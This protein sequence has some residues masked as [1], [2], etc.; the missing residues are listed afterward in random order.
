MPTHHPITRQH[1]HHSWLS[2][3][4]LLCASLACGA[5]QV[6]VHDP[7]MTREGDTWYLFSTGPGITIYSSKD[8]VNWRYSDRA[9]GTEPTWAKRVSPSFDGHLWAPDIYQHKGLFYLYYSVSAF[10][11]NTS[12]IGV[13]VNK[14]LN[15]AS[16]DYRWED[17]G[18]VIES[19]P[20]RDLWN[21]IDPAIIADDHGQVWMSFGSFWGGLKLFKLNDDL[22]RPAEPQEWHSIAK[23]ERS[24]LMDDSQAG[25]AQIEAPF[26]LRKGD[27]YYLFASWGLCC[28]KGDS[29]YHLVV[30]RSK[31]VT[32]PYLDKT[33]R[34]M[35]QGGGSLLIKGNKRWVGLGH[36]SAYT[37]D[38]KDYLVLHAYE[39]ADNYLQK[40]KILNLH[41]DGEGWPQVDEKELDSYI[42]QRLK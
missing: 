2:A 8:R 31:Q 3:L 20:Q 42:S 13:T 17:K 21:A 35:N 27:Y 16:P 38:G 7:V 10:G 14:T 11:K 18:I 12:A 39:A 37:W 23:L 40:L 26:I 36:N 19:V 1:W 30:G 4:A 6:D 25:S 9:F 41:W 32:G 28:R 29:T 5:K 33:G 22:T 24:V 15:P 34:D